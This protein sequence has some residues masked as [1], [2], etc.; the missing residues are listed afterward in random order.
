MTDRRSLVPS[1]VA[2]TGLKQGLGR[3]NNG[4]AVENLAGAQF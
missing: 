2:D 4:F 1:H 3:R